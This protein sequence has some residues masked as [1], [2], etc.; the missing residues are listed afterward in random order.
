ML[1][2]QKEP[3]RKTLLPCILFL[4]AILFAFAALCP[5][6]SAAA[7]ETDFIELYKGFFKDLGSK[8]YEKVWDSMTMASKKRLAKLITDMAVAQ[9]KSVTETQV[10]DMLDKNT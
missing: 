2:K 6:T 1:H 7:S 9:G 8:K 4:T 5:V 10:F 3:E